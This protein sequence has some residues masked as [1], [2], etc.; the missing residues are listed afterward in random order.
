MSYS[1]K[2]WPLILHASLPRLRFKIAFSIGVKTDLEHHATL[3]FSCVITLQVA[4]LPQGR[5]LSTARN[6]LLN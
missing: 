6:K 3:R 2:T 4:N 1:T 5:L